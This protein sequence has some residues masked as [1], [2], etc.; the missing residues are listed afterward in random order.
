MTH[1][2]WAQIQAV[3]AAAVERTGESRGAYLSQ[4]CAGDEAL[5]SEVESLLSAHDSA[6][7][8]FLQSPAAIEG[9]TEVQATPPRVTRR[10]L[11]PGTRL[12]SYE[13]LASI[14][15]GGM[16]EVYRAFDS[17]L[18]RE[19]AVKV[20]PQSFANDPEALVRF[21]REALAVAALSHPNI[22]SI[23]DFGREGDTAYAV[24]ELLDGHTLREK[25]KTGPLPLN[26]ILHYAIQI[27]EGLAAAHEKEI[28]HRDLKPENLFITKD[29]RVKILDFGLAKRVERVAP[30]EETSAETVEG[31]HTKAGM[32]M[33]TLGYMSPEQLLGQD[34]DHRTELF[35]FG[36]VL[37]EMIA[38]K[39]PFQGASVMAISDAILHKQPPELTDRKLP[40]KLKGIIRQLLEKERQKR[41]ETAAE[42]L[43]EVK[44]L[45]A[46]LA[47]G[48]FRLSTRARLAVATTLLLAVTAGAL[49][50]RRAA[51]ER[52]AL[53][54]AVPEIQRLIGDMEHVKAAVLARQAR[55]ILPDDPT[56]EKLW[57]KCTDTVSIETVPAG[58]EVSVRVAGD[59]SAAWQ[60]LGSTPLS[61]IRLANAAYTV[62]VSKTGYAPWIVVDG[63]PMEWSDHHLFPESEVPDGMVPIMNEE[64]SL[65]WPLNGLP[66]K[67]VDYFFMDRFE[68]TNADYRKF[69]DAKG[70]ETPEF[71]RERFIRNGREVSWAE[72]MTQFRDA[73]GRPGPSSWEAGTYPPGR[74]RHPVAGV[75]WY[76]AAAYARFAGK[77]LPTVYHWAEAAQV[78]L[79][80]LIARGSNFD[81]TET[82]EVG[83]PEGLSGFGTYDMA[84][85]VKEWCWNESRDGKRFILGGGYGE[86]SY[87]FVNV[88]AQSTWDRRATFG[89]RCAKYRNPV[90]PDFSAKLDPP[91]RD[92]G[93]EKPVSDSV[94]AAFRGLYEYDRADLDVRTL[95]S[96]ETETWTEEVVSIAAAYGQERLPIHLYL[97]KGVLPPYQTVIYYPGGNGYWLDE[98]DSSIFEYIWNF[99]P[100][101]GRA[102]VYPVYRGM[103][104]RNDGLKDGGP[105]AARR[106]RMIMQAK[107]LGRT[108][109]YLATRTDI[110]SSRL[111][112]SGF[113]AGAA[114]A[115]VLLAVQPRF[116]AAILTSGGFW[117][118]NP[119][120]EVDWIN[121]ITR[122]K[123]PVLMI[124]GRWDTGFPEVTSQ[125]PFFQLLGAPAENKRHVIFEAGHGDLPRREYMREVLDWL[126]KYLGPVKK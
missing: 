46:A 29:G 113:S 92:Y 93:K 98:F 17:K 106:D 45:E 63:P 119:L 84:G 121:F 100:K 53:E 39:A 82:R 21:E 69:V 31:G 2:R 38:R 115:P 101:S 124:N 116:R 74:E 94:F 34:V 19:V 105:P 8:R 60:V 68:V 47:P 111:A 23:Y 55:A 107:D 85:N 95:A 14:G 59:D 13:I 88:D 104:E 97:P 83:R 44:D 5:R 62:R 120:P 91:F 30:G 20:L 125:R 15:A 42:L 123:I 112:Y 35:S 56:L 109:D 51:R 48:R 117:F 52:W 36:V 57:L 89:F 108:L 87:M 110:D 79:L 49:L 7:S 86:P 65:G 41:H 81:G 118:R 1:E 40:A 77:N 12:G 26:L 126:D 28:V 22:L 103:F 75:S 6:S 73:T 9:E 76:E 58:A 11:P 50:W 43:A 114:V 72:A 64:V 33:G 71:W 10:G 99:L 80:S 67:K 32:V 54:I 18:R 27:A 16:G 66:P 61:G 90:S 25:L 24:M 70:Y 37:Y 102:V 122:V 3:F 4:I 96:R 78:H